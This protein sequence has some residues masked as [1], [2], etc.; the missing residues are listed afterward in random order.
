MR[1]LIARS[2]EFGVDVGEARRAENL[3]FTDGEWEFAADAE[4]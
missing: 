2:V 1:A 3:G 4:G